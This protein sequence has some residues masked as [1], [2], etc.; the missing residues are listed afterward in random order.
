MEMH[1]L[2]GLQNGAAQ[3]HGSEREMSIHSSK[4]KVCQVLI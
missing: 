4:S 3:G 2:N 1:G